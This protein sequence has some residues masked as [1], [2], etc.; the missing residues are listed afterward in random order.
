[1][2]SV[3][4]SARSVDKAINLALEE[5]GLHRDE[6]EVDILQ[7]ESSG[8]LG[9]FGRKEGRVRVTPIKGARYEESTRPRAAKTAAEPKKKSAAHRAPVSAEVTVADKSKASERTTGRRKPIPDGQ[10]ATTASEVVEK[11]ATCFGITVEVDGTETESAVKLRVVGEGVGQ[12]IGRRGKTLGA[13][14]YMVSR[15]LNEDRSV[16]KKI[17]IDV[18][19][20]NED[21]EQTLRELAE[22]TADRVIRN[23][24]PTSLRPMSAQERRVIHVTLQD[25]VEAGTESF[26]E[27]GRRQ[28]VVYPKSM[29]PE[30]LERFIESESRE[31]GRRSGAY[32]GRNRGRGRGGNG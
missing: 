17:T 13:V 32:R 12:L 3:E 16:R 9:V 24:K 4:K 5:L 6:V 31:S 29:S 30:E 10:L 11:I 14:Q 28:V 1:M 19:G 2:Q 26:G 20:Y 15:L 21:R 27:E 7:L 18:D 22:R 23:R 8:V 25:D